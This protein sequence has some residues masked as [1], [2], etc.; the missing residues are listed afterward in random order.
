MTQVLVSLDA[1]RLCSNIG[2]ASGCGATAPELH[3]FSYLGCLLSVYDNSS[4]GEWGYGFH[5]TPTGS[6]YAPELDKAVQWLRAAGLLTQDGDAALTLSME[7]EADLE[8]L[9]KH[10]SVAAR[11]QY[12]DAAGAAAVLMPLPSVTSALSHEPQLERVLGTPQARNLL[13]KAGRQLIA[14][15]FETVAAAFNDNGLPDPDLALAATVWLTALAEE[16]PS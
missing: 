3:A 11:L 10:E 16:E 13:D 9:A 15:H 4:M 14:P 7:G 6:P 1:L 12:L 2:R 8:Q 5:A